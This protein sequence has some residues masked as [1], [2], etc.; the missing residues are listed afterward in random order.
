[1][2]VGPY[3][4]GP[5][6]PV[7]LIAGPC[8]L[9][10]LDETLFL[11]EAIQR[12]VGARPLVFKASFDKANRTRANAYRGP[13]L[14]L[15]L[16]WLAIIKEKTGLLIT[17]DIH[18]PEQAAAVAKIADLVQIPAFL[19]RQ[20]DLLAEAG[21][22]GLPVNIKKGQFLAPE[23]MGSAREKA[24]NAGASGVLLTERGTTFGYGDLVVDMRAIPR[25]MALGSPV[26]F[27]C[28][29]SLQAPGPEGSGGSAE[30][31]PRMAAASIVMGASVI[32]AEVHPEPWRARSDAATQ[33]PLARLG[34]L[35]ERIQRAED[36]R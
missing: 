34:A 25:M 19:A 15:G 4:F 8:V 5:E 12:Q 11:A 27:D 14:A 20:T 6:Q 36:A 3:T 21:A 35:L 28:T 23:V 32:F 31:A 10:D 2:R 13:G 7:A 26:C 9:E 33:L 30:L 18:L 29:H 17:T 24:L 16:E 1:M 22:T